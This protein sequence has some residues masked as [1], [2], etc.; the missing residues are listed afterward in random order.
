MALIPRSG[1]PLAALRDLRDFVAAPRKHKMVF[2]ALSFA[3][4]ALIIFGML[5]QAHVDEVWVPP[6]IIYVKQW[7]ANRSIVEVRAQ[8][9]KD[10]PA[11]IA[12]K[13]QRDAEAETTRQA[14]RR[15]ADRFGIDVDKQRK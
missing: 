1:S 5:R 6:T 14:F 10:L 4:P 15:V 13:K 11:E 8:Q 3:L 12:A 9:A 2:A 7:P